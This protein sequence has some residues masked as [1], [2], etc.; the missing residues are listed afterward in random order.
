MKLTLILVL[1]FFMQAIRSSHAQQ[2]E[3]HT[4][5]SQINKLIV[6]SNFIWVGTNGGLLKLDKNARLLQKYTIAEGLIGNS[7]IDMKQDEAGRILIQAG[8]EIQTIEN[9]KLRKLFDSKEDINIQFLHHNSPL[10]YTYRQSILLDKIKL[11]YKNKWISY[12]VGLLY[13]SS[14]FSVLVAQEDRLWF[15]YKKGVMLWDKGALKPYPFFK[16]QTFETLVSMAKDRSGGNWV[17]TSEDVYVYKAQEDKWVTYEGIYAEQIKKSELLYQD[18]SNNLWFQDENGNVLYK[19]DGKSWET[20]AIKLQEEDIQ[21]GMFTSISAITEDSYGDIWIG[22][23]KGN[24]YN[25]S[26]SN[27]EW[28]SFSIPKSSSWIGKSN[29]IAGAFKDSKGNIW[30]SYGSSLNLFDPSKNKRITFTEKDINEQ[31]PEFFPQEI[32]EDQYGNI[33]VNNTQGVLKYD[34]DKWK[35]FMQDSSIVYVHNG[36]QFH[37]YITRRGILL[38]TNKKTGELKEFDLLAGIKESA[39]LHKIY[40][41]E[42]FYDQDETIWIGRDY[43]SIFFDGK[44]TKLYAATRNRILLKDNTNRLWAEGNLNEAKLLRFDGEN[45]NPVYLKK[46][47]ID[48]NP[49][50]FGQNKYCLVEDRVGAVFAVWHTRKNKITQYIN[51]KWKSNRFLV[52]FCE[53]KLISSIWFDRQNNLWVFTDK[54][55]FKID[56]LNKKSQLYLN[57]DNLHP[58]EIIEDE[59]GAIWLFLRDN[60]IIKITP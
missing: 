22:T 25:Y 17:L 18:K 51:G 1:V 13:Y 19:Y 11:R 24:L 32:T 23:T 50:F 8:S 37:D 15:S 27:Q 26:N 12:P 20:L 54:G 14:N 48:W 42:V 28:T 47:K 38:R 53:D 43:Q 57:T 5:H 21:R 41:A 46:S 55:L 39:F 2:V 49:I 52:S 33:W 10:G 6:D 16:D 60:G 4:S 36:E 30:W 34:G 45:W 3:N 59:K 31:L 35:G 40:A 56:L 44:S 29:F 9:G 58:K 7:I